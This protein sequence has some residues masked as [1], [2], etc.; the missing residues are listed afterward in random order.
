MVDGCMRG[1]GSVDS[2]VT[3]IILVVG[4]RGWVV[5]HENNTTKRRIVS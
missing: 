1:Y 3:I 5:V 4:D 2:V